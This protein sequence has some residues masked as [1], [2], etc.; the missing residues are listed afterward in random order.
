M[1]SLPMYYQN[2]LYGDYNKDLKTNNSDIQQF[3]NYYST[4]IGKKPELTQNDRGKIISEFINGYSTG[5]GKTTTELET[6]INQRTTDYGL[7]T[8][9][10][11]REAWKIIYGS[12]SSQ[13][14]QPQPQPQSQTT[15]DRALIELSGIDRTRLRIAN[16]PIND[17]PG[18]YDIFFKGKEVLEY[19]ASLNGEG[20]LNNNQID[21]IFKNLFNPIDY[22]DNGYKNH[23]INGNQLYHARKASQDDDWETNTVYKIFSNCNFKIE[24]ISSI[25]Y[26]DTTQSNETRVEHPNIG[27]KPDG[28]QEVEILSPPVTL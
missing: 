20:T 11:N 8:P 1:T 14:S 25:R 22:T 24:S 18:H 9:P 13:D 19:K 21:P 3:I 26:K 4:I 16:I 17:N 5:K 28:T 10:Y 2:Y 23:I 15:L 12:E 6:I 27:A 7:N